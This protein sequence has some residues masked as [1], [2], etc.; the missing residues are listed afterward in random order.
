MIWGIEEFKEVE[1][2]VK[3]SAKK[4]ISAEKTKDANI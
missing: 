2:N 4:Y 3:P 1:D